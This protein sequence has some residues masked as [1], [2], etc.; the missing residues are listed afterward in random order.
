M[1]RMHVFAVL[2]IVITGIA[3]CSK[4]EPPPPPPAPKAEAPAPAPAPAA[5]AE[6]SVLNINLGKAIGPDKKVTTP[7][8]TFAKS[9]TIY[10]VIETQGAGNAT[11]KA[12][13]TYHKGDQTAVVDENTQ[14]ISATGPATTEFHISKPDGWPAGE[15]QVEVTL[16]DKPAGMKKFSVN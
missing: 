16:N 4:E 9:D 7:T 3:G 14:T 8:E 10:A 1:K 13:W 2:A 12:K 11:L 5:P 15:Y 6:V